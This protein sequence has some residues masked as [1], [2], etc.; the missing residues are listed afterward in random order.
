MAEQLNSLPGKSGHQR[1]VDTA[2]AD[3]ALVI[4]PTYN[5]AE[6]IGKLLNDLSE[7]YPSVVD[8]LVIDDNSP[9]GTQDIVRAMQA[10]T[11][12][13]Y[14]ITRERKLGLGTAYIT[15]F[16]YALEH[17]Y[18]YIIEMDADYSHDPAMIKQF[19]EAMKGADLVIGS[20]YMNN[21]V[22][23][24]N[25]PLGRLIL[26]KLASIYTRMVTGLPVADPTSG[27]KCFS[28]KVLGALDLDRINSQ[29]YSFQIEM[30]FRAWK[31]G[32]TIK[33]VPIV[34]IDRTV[35]KSK[36]TRKNIREAIWI[37]WWLK[38]KSIFGL[39]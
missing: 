7:L 34:F 36:M 4:I 9:D 33:E 38:L 26:S 23:V 5:E 25:W 15:G 10:T 39:L 16:R 14:M 8:K 27:F 20:R 30:N 21:T 1:T 35:G 28:A 31:K 24:V 37:V 17:D 29:G 3:R 11:S 22:N 2:Q 18:R 13:L 12:G 19:M 6:N 32:F